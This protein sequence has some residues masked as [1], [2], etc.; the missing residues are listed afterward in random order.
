MA[1]R[2]APSGGYDFEEKQKYRERVWGAFADVV[3]DPSKAVCL[4]MPSEEGLE[5]PVALGL[6]FKE[7]NLI[8]VDKDMS[9]FES[10]E[11]MYEYPNIS[12]IVSDIADLTPDKVR[13]ISGHTKID[14]AN[15]DLCGNVSSKTVGAVYSFLDQ[16]SVLG[17]FAISVTLLAG[18]DNFLFNSVVSS[19]LQNMPPNYKKEWIDRCVG[20]EPNRA[21][22]LLFPYFMQRSETNPVG[23]TNILSSSYISIRN[24]KMEYGVFQVSTPEEVSKEREAAVSCIEAGSGYGIADAPP[25]LFEDGGFVLDYLRRTRK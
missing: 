1:G 23:I 21:S 14:A 4:F 12:C 19:F 5:I 10:A 20:F 11:W 16:F 24:S 22:H 2:I 17:G 15:L 3:N 13:K 6:G 8:A 25:P 9:T 7:E 18:R